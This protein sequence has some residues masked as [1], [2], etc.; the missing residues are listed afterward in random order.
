MVKNDFNELIQ[1]LLLIT[2]PMHHILGT[3][4]P[5]TLHLFKFSYWKYLVTEKKLIWME[6]YHQKI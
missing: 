5:A 1:F 4:R 6:T 3:R 2:A